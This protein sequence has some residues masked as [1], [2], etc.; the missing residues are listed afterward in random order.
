M[1]VTLQ[2]A[3]REVSGKCYQ[4]IA[5]MKLECSFRC[6]PLRQEGGEAE[7]ISNFEHFSKYNVHLFLYLVHF[8]ISFLA[9]FIKRVQPK[10][11]SIIYD[12]NCHSQEACY[13][14]GWGSS[15]FKTIK[16]KFQLLISQ[17]YCP[18]FFSTPLGRSFIV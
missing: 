18:N 16:S 9:T 8:Q 6:C 17:P 11:V 14:I 5:N 13:Y 2:R 7:N 10:H 1:C 3:A 4:N 12:K 15:M